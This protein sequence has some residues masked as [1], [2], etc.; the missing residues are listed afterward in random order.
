MHDVMRTA[1]VVM[2]RDVRLAWIP[3]PSLIRVLLFSGFRLLAFRRHR[4]NKSIL[5]RSVHPCCGKVKAEP[6]CH[7]LF[8]FQSPLFFELH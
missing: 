6:V 3:Y 4:A 7:E 1:C 8:P 5:G 2:L